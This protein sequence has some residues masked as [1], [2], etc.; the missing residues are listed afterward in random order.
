M[1]ASFHDYIIALCRAE[2]G[3]VYSNLVHHERFLTLKPLD[4][5]LPAKVHCMLGGKGCPR[6]KK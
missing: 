4:G 3:S 2:K 6:V 5:Q 1:H